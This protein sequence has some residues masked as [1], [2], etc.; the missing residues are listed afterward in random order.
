MASPSDGLAILLPPSETKA[1][2]GEG[3]ALDI[4][5]LAFAAELTDAR[6]RL[7]DAVVALSAAPDAARTALGLTVHQDDQ[8]ALNAELLTSPTTEA[9]RRYTGVLYDALG[10]RSLRPA[11]RERARAQVFVASALF[12]IVAGGD[13]VP[14]YRLSAGSVLPDLGR[15]IPIWKPALSPVLT[16]LPGFVVDLRSGAYAALAPVSTAV[17][18]RVLAEHPDG[19]RT[20]VSHFSKHH[21]GLLARAL[22][23]A[24]TTPTTVEGVVKVARRAGLRVEHPSARQ[25]DVLTSL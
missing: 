5:R 12:G 14:A 2:G 17:T 10:Y 1:L 19:S 3:P 20:V 9:L 22:L 18:V 16:T 25:I 11:M 23:R 8:I 15:L 24:R 7:L 4:G 13:P 6:K 21:K